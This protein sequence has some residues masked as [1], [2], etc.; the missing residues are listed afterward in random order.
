MPAVAAIDRTHLINFDT[1]IVRPETE[2]QRLEFRDDG[3]FAGS[4][5]LTCHGEGHR[6]EHY[7]K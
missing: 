1:T 5:T 7:R 3:R 6:D 4:C 2:S